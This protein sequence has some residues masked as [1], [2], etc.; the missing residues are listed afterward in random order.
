M[1][2]SL[3][4]NGVVLTGE[5][6]ERY[7]KRKGLCHICARVVTHK[8]AGKL[9]RRNQ[10]KPLTVQNEETNDYVVYKG[11]C[12]QPT[13]YTLDQA[14][15]CLGEK[16]T[17]RLS[18]RGSTSMRAGSTIGLLTISPLLKSSSMAGKGSR[19]HTTPGPSSPFARVGSGSSYAQ[20]RLSHGSASGS[21]RPLRENHGRLSP[22]ASVNSMAGSVSSARYS[23][24][25]KQWSRSIPMITLPSVT[26]SNHTSSGPGTGTA[27]P[28]DEDKDID[29]DLAGAIANLTA[30]IYAKNQKETSHSREDSFPENQSTVCK[31]NAP[32]VVSFCSRLTFD[33]KKSEGRGTLKKSMGL[34]PG[35][36]KG[37]KKKKSKGES[38][39]TDDSSISSH[40]SS[41]SLF[42]TSLRSQLPGSGFVVSAEGNYRAALEALDLADGP[43][44]HGIGEYQALCLQSKRLDF[45]DIEMVAVEVDSMN[46]HWMSQEFLLEEDDAITLWDYDYEHTTV[47]DLS[48]G[49]HTVRLSHVYCSGAEQLELEAD[50]QDFEALER[51]R[52][53]TGKA[54]SSE[55]LVF[56][57]RVSLE[58]EIDA[59]RE[60]ISTAEKS[61]DP[62]AIQ[63][64]I[65]ARNHLNMLLPLRK[66][67]LSKREL[68][69]KINGLSKAIA[70]LSSNDLDR[71]YYLATQKEQLL[72]QVEEERREEEFQKLQAETIARALESASEA[73]ETDYQDGNNGFKAGTIPSVPD[74]DD[75]SEAS[76]IPVTEVALKPHAEVS[77]VMSTLAMEDPSAGIDVNMTVF[78]S[79][80]LAYVDHSTGTH[81]V[82]PLLDFQYEGR[83][84][85]Q[86][87][88]D[89]ETVGAKVDIKFD[90][91]TTDRLSAFLAKSESRVMHLSC[92]GHPKYLALEN[93]FGG[94]QILPVRDLK[95]FIAC[96]TGN[97]ELVFVSACHSMAAGKAFLDAGIRHVICCRQD[98]KFRDEGAI[99]F[100]R[101][102]YRAL[103][104]NNT[105][106]QAFKM[107]REAMRISPMVKDSKAEYEKFILL[108]E[109]PSK[110]PY[111]DV[112]IFS[113][114]Y[115]TRALRRRPS[116]LLR[117]DILTMRKSRILPK[118]PQYFVGREMDMYTI[119]DALRSNEI[120]S[121]QGPPD[122]GKTSLV[123][124]LTRYIEQRHKSFLFDDVFWLP[125][126]E[127]SIP[128]DDF[129][130]HDLSRLFEMIK[131][132]SDVQQDRVYT[133]CW[134]HVLRQLH[135]KRV[136]LVVHGRS[137]DSPAA[138]A[139]LEA[140]LCDLLSVSNA[141]II[142]VGVPV[143]EEAGPTTAIIDVE[144]LD[145]DASVLLFA[146]L[147]RSTSAST[148]QI[149]KTLTSKPSSSKKDGPS[150]EKLL[151]YRQ[152]R[153]FERIGEGFPSRI[154]RAALEMSEE[155]VVELLRVAKRPLVDVDS[156]AELETKLN[157]LEAEEG[158]ELKQSNFINARNIRETIEE[159]VCLREDFPTVEELQA[160]E[161][162][163]EQALQKAIS[164]KRYDDAGQQKKRLTALQEQI[165]K[166]LSHKTQEGP[167]KIESLGSF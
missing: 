72:S 8:R 74:A 14:K 148:Q 140:F 41:L 136:L 127:G 39:P 133:D 56:R 122:I 44:G 147:T 17:T 85:T 83:A 33:E 81:H 76:T 105:L 88:K 120:V 67:Y 63:N 30:A 125:V 103:A 2:S 36:K 153:M 42:S 166:E 131:K 43:G 124:A 55:F 37:L 34:F 53:K 31:S 154:R 49:V 90:I 113:S 121:I 70:A 118:V 69:K 73:P 23:M 77:A 50:L 25:N 10:W 22:T 94:M 162:E 19:R 104:L 48:T 150:K 92:H 101:T 165:S 114:T 149:V 26:S 86:S 167:T 51:V 137:I 7:S 38:E 146:S 128:P 54:S 61:D 144:A 130:C 110:D 78:Q 115:E 60:T 87:L 142:T 138:Q 135:D 100:A 102:F 152:R 57:T 47:Q 158:V 156:R 132:D 6:L 129:L 99:E 45:L 62:S 28:T 95:R 163:V 68:Q 141:K 16:P 64:G 27:T 24:S 18:I 65:D 4:N 52:I 159:L 145:Y 58:T 109:R 91:A 106:K 151:A 29:Q 161:K 97:L 15:E 79:A 126:Q 40:T 3:C 75:K 139:N 11:Y 108:P 9:L 20:R 155:D 112:H 89:A 12:I 160:E 117:Q 5:D 107:A 84:L 1:N 82:C 66:F 93:G 116:A 143:I 35:L 134:G 46:R 32:S 59:C 164:F 119:L 157:E 21:N 111:H 71:R 13:C 123:A 80:P 96:G 98:D